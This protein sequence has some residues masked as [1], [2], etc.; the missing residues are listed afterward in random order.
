MIQTLSKDIEFEV[1]QLPK[2]RET[3]LKVV[4]IQDLLTFDWGSQ[5]EILQQKI[6]TLM[7]ILKSSIG[8]NLNNRLPYVIVGA[9]VILYGRCQQLNLLQYIIGLT[10]DRCGLNKEGLN[11]LHDIGLSVS[12]TSVHNKR[13][14][15]V[16]QH[17]DNLNSVVRKMSTT[18]PF[19]I[20]QIP[21]CKK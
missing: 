5:A 11:I 6:P 14:S 19:L 18:S 17:E 7:S 8:D 1:S 9:S 10:L 20:V 21:Y 13:K 4:S 3:A 12:Y 16:K 15:L 2:R